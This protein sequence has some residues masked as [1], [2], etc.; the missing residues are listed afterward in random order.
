MEAILKN[1]G[2][3]LIAGVCLVLLLALLLV[4]ITDEQGNRGIFKIIGARLAVSGTDYTAYS[5]F[6]TYG[7]ESEK[8]YPEITFD[9]LAGM[10]VGVRKITDYVTA[11]DFAGTALPIRFVKFED[12]MGN[13]LTDTVN[14][15]TMEIPFPAPGIYKVTV[16]AIDNENRKTVTDICVPVN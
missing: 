13:D 16:A 1:Y 5:D 12:A 10:N 14:A 7:I 15:A 9:G 4:G 2:K 8:S 3:F 11:V 6:D